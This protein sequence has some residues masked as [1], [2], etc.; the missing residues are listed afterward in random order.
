MSALLRLPRFGGAIP[1][2]HSVNG[3][4]LDFGFAQAK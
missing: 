2:H 3:I 1:A 4:N